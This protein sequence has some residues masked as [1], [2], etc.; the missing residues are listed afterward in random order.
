M[1]MPI[2][3]AYGLWGSLGVVLTA[4]FSYLL[5]NDT[6]SFQSAFGIAVIVFGI[7]LIQLG[8]AK[9]NKAANSSSGTG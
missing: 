9:Q 1:G 5:L 7:V 4:V 2:A 6:M 8:D 3:V